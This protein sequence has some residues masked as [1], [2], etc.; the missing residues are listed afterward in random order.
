[1]TLQDATGILKGPDDAATQYFRR[2]GEARLTERFQPMVREATDKAGVTAA[3]KRLV[4]Q[5]GPF[6]QYLGK[7]AGDLDGYITRRALDG[8]FLMIAEEEKRIRTDPV[9]RGTELLK[10]V[11]GAATR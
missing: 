3:Y 4:T 7:D 2:T 1:M 6:A 8:L 10:K 11:F 5:L 9:A